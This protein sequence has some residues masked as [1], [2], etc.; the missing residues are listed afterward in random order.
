[1]EVERES[2]RRITRLEEKFDGLRVDL[3]E[4]SEITRV[5]L[6][7]IYERLNGQNETLVETKTVLNMNTTMLNQIAE[8]LNAVEKDKHAIKSLP[9]MLGWLAA[10]GASITALAAYLKPWGNH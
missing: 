9:R 4:H 5:H 3:K 6:T 2:D 8:K 7:G 10:L 1:M